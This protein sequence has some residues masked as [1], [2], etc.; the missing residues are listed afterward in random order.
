MDGAGRRAAD[1]PAAARVRVR[2]RPS[3]TN[4]RF[5]MNY[6]NNDILDVCS[7]D[8]AGPA[9]PSLDRQEHEAPL[10]SALWGR[11]SRLA[12]AEETE[13]DLLCRIEDAESMRRHVPAFLERKLTRVR[14]RI[15]IL[16]AQ[17]L[18]LEHQ[19]GGGT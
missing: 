10:W 4:R 9:S 15:E 1:F 19:L 11:R 7:D 14:E 6:E 5:P 2:P 13:I 12:N 17:I 8:Y 18:S 16:H 3:T